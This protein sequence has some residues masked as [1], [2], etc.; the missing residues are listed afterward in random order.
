[1]KQIPEGY[2][3]IGFASYYGYDCAGNKTANGEKFNPNGLT[4]AH[5][6]L[7]FN[8]L[9]RVTNLGNSKS[10]VVR[11]NDRGPHARNRI[12]DLAYGAAKRI[13]LVRAGHAK[14]KIEVVTQP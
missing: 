1:V 3:E 12:I 9:L 6:T 10:V 2:T 14:V 7:P 8:T 11:V 4:A 13:D 5:R